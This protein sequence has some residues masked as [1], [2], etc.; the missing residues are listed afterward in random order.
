M[1]RKMQS[2][3]GLTL[4]E[5]LVAMAIGAILILGVS[6]TFVT[7]KMSHSLQLGIGHVQEGGR[8]AVAMMSRDVRMAD[9]W[10]CAKNGINLSSSIGFN[11]NDDKYDFLTGGAGGVSG[12]DVV[13]SM[14]IDGLPVVDGSSVVTLRGAQPSSCTVTTTGTDLKLATIGISGCEVKKNTVVAISNCLAGDIF[15]N[16]AADNASVLGYKSTGTTP[17]NNAGSQVIHCGVGNDSC[18]SQPYEVGAQILFPYS[19]SYFVSVG[20][21]GEPGLYKY[22]ALKNNSSELIDGVESMKVSYAID[23]DYDSTKSIVDLEAPSRSV[24]TYMTAKQINQK[25]N[26]KWEQVIGLKVDLL[27][28]SDDGVRSESKTVTFNGVNYGGADRRMR[29][30][31]S[32]VMNIRNRSV[33][34]SEGL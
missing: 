25:P 24:H 9:Y 19:V 13:G 5:L 8:M 28:R 22:D 1:K 23:L 6:E 2:Q 29:E 12:K 11:A 20:A 7:H 17:P 3:L 10:G 4:V 32:S 31:F 30:I 16:S 15:V 26:I 14:T 33:P 27:L 34:S 18:L 21:S